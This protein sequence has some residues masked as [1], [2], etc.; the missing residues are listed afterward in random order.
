M[1]NSNLINEQALMC[2]PFRLNDLVMEIKETKRL[3]TNKLA[4]L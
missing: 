2:E 3:V 4:I 1:K